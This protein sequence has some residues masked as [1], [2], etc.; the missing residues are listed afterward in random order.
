MRDHQ[1]V[2]CGL[3]F[4]ELHK[5]QHTE[6][7]DVAGN[8][9]AAEALNSVEH[10]DEGAE[11]LVGCDI[12]DDTGRRAQVFRRS[13]TSGFRLALALGLTAVLAI[14]GLGG[15]LG[16][17]AYRVHGEDQLRQQFLA[18]GK[19]EALNLTTIDY[20]EADADVQRV[21]DS[22]T[23]EFYNDFSKRTQPFIDAVKQAHSKTQGTVTDAG[24]EWV[25]RDQAQVLVAVAVTTSTVDTQEQQPRP[26]RMRIG[27]QR[28]GDGAKVSNV[29]FVP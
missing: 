26:W 16:Y 6:G 8:L 9:D 18:V 2:T 23:G 7:A 5:A 19:Q 24:L 14:G 27:V 12:G 13:G 17:G 28:V 29:E 3:A 11:A 21:V 20:T 25:E 15:W 22:S 4:D 10:V 1:L